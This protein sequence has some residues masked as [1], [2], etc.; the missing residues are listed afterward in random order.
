MESDIIQIALDIIGSYSHIAAPIAP[1]DRCIGR[2]EMGTQVG[3][4][5]VELDHK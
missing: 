3:V 1:S 4:E 2:L 5:V